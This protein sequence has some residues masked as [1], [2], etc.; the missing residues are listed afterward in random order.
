MSNK[1]FLFLRK[2]MQNRRPT[3]SLNYI[4][5][6]LKINFLI[7]LLFLFVALPDGFGQNLDSLQNKPLMV[8]DGDSLRKKLTQK[9]SL[10]PKK[11][12][13]RV[14]TRKSAILPG[15]GQIYIKQYWF[16]PAIYGG[17][18]ACAYMIAYNGKRYRAF[19]EAYF[20]TSEAQAS[21]G[22]VTINGVPKKY[23]ISTL[24]LGTSVYRRYRDLS[25]MV[26]PVVWAVNV[27]EVNVSAH[28]K[29]F[30]M[31]DDITLKIQPSFSPG[32]NGMPSLGLKT[33]FAFK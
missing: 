10:T 17:F 33:V 7:A 25:W 22:E 15:S 18:G 23:S 24:K 16:L 14:A 1:P 4:G 6:K 19:R 30:D 28:L 11:I 2:K 20:A 8:L 21:E 26:I 32:A 31:S 29:T 13:P 27:L 3:Y 12:D 9:D 5:N